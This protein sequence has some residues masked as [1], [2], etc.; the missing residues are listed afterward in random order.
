M[1]ENTPY[2]VHSSQS[3][4]HAFG[5]LHL[6]W[7]FLSMVKIKFYSPV[8]VGNGFRVLLKKNGHFFAS[9]SV[10]DVKQ[11]RVQLEKK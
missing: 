6:L 8:C 3:V 9:P 4:V 1:G 2:R 5:S 11:S 10:S 7:L